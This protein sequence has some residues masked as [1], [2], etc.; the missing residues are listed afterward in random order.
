M[1]SLRVASGEVVLVERP[2]GEVG[3]VAMPLPVQP[4]HSG[5]NCTG[6][7]RSRGEMVAESA[8]LCRMGAMV[9]DNSIPGAQVLWP[10]DV[11]IP[12][13]SSMVEPSGSNA[14]GPLETAV[15]APGPEE[16]PDDETITD[17]DA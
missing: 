5:G 9:G 6:S 3:Q 8:D 13:R 2:P 15:H 4:V 12:A 10:R 1:G 17:M 14:P 7:G 16:Q 11:E